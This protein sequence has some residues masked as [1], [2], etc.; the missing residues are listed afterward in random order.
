MM[1]GTRK[2]TQS[3]KRATVVLAIAFAMFAST[4][5]VEAQPAEKL[6]RIGFL[7]MG[8]RAPNHPWM[9]AFR[10]GLRAR[11][12]VEGKSFVIEQRH[13]ARR[14]E[15]LRAAAAELDGTRDRENCREPV[16]ECE[17]CDLSLIGSDLG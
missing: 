10:D 9:V 15:R 6:H 16:F 8:P 3:M 14:R 12:Y 17:R 2:G 13:G 11:G 5:P 4:M 7:S 1:G